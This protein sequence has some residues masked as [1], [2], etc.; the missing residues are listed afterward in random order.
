MTH[1]RNPAPT[2]PA[3]HRAFADARLREGMERAGID[4]LIAL[5][6]ENFY[7]LTGY[8]SALLQH[9]RLAGS[10]I[11]MLLRDPDRPRVVIDMEFMAATYASA[12]SGLALTTYPT[13]TYVENPYDWPGV[14]LDPE[15]S[16][17]ISVEKAIGRLAGVLAKQT[18]VKRIGVDLAGVQHTTWQALVEMLPDF[19]IVDA[20]EIFSNAQAIKSEWEIEQ[21]VCATNITTRA[22]TRTAEYLGAGMTAKEVHRRFV[23]ECFADP[24]TT[25]LRFAFW[26][27]GADFS[28]TVSNHREV[29]AKT[30]DLIKFDGGAEHR[31]YG[32]DFA[33]GFCVGEPDSRTADTYAALQEAQRTLVAGAELGR[34]LADMYTEAMDVARRGIPQYRRGHLGHS[35][36]LSVE[37]APHV[38]AH[39]TA[40]IEPGMVLSLELP[41][42]GYGVGAINIED[43]VVASSD[44]VRVITPM[45]KELVRV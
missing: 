1:D 3:A 5:G 43:M 23:A 25:G 29:P 34:P 9:T 38:S 10:S 2:A 45:T 7:Y 20:G 30:G 26:S 31:G 11:G 24:E 22:L 36:G 27:V 21:I 14:E 41:Y 39:E 13:W 16:T 18:G 19:E 40:V 17:E 15:L 8:T 42:Y 32:A 28:S 4:A 35:T 12:D 44:G 6:P 33:R 37:M